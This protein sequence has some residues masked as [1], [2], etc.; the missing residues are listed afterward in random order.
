MKSLTLTTIFHCIQ[1]KSPSGVASDFT[2]NFIIEPFFFQEQSVP[3]LITYF[4]TAIRYAS[5]L[6]RV[7]VPDIP[8]RGIFGSMIILVRVWNGSLGNILQTTGGVDTFAFYDCL[9][10]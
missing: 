6:Q 4:V 3:E 5:L 7:V 9:S 1:P 2:A 10:H 8:L